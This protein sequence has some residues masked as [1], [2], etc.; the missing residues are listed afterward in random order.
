L[1]LDRVIKQ[2][3]QINTAA[4]Q[5]PAVMCS[6]TREDFEGMMLSPVISF[7]EL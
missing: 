1:E 5:R 3:D 4:S 6:R 7:S 2:L